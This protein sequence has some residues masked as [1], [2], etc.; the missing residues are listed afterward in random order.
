[1]PVEPPVPE[2]PVPVDPPVP[3]EPPVPVAPPVPVEPPVSFEPPVPDPPPP[4]E[5]AENATAPKM[6]SGST[7]AENNR[8]DE[9]VIMVNQVPRAGLFG[10]VRPRA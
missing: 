2:P 9:L 8:R 3:V 5:Q 1:M 7:Y 10:T 4:L 6:A